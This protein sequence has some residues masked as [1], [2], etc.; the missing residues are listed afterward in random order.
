MTQISLALQALGDGKLV[1]IPT[2]TV[3]GLAAPINSKIHLERIFVL[4]ERP[5]FDPLIVHVHSIKQARELVIDWPPVAEVLARAFWPG[6]L[7]LILEKKRDRVDD[8]ITSG[9]STVGVRMPNHPMTLQFL[10]QLDCPLAAPS[11]NKFTQTS[12]TKAQDVR[13]VFQDSDVFVLDGGPCL[14]GVESTIVQIL[15]DE[16]VIL[17]LGMV[18]KTDLEQA[19]AQSGH[20]VQIRTGAA[21]LESVPGNFSA[22]YKPKWPVVSSDQS[23]SD[24]QWVSIQAQSGLD[25]KLWQT[26]VLNSNPQLAAR[27]LYSMLRSPLEPD[28]QALVILFDSKAKTVVE[29][30]QWQGLRDRLKKAS[31]FHFIA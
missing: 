25:K 20:R 5:F 16:L 13:D 3:Y 15:K 28:K 22:H 24:E 2:E 8:L 4:K 17:R 1:A 27:E 29:Q 12:P 18:T 10:E 11:A 7:T 26:R 14:V 6:P 9:L 19:L 30:E 23:I 31:L 21:H